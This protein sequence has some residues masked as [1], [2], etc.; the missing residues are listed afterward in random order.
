[1]GFTSFREDIVERFLGDNEIMKNELKAPKPDMIKLQKIQ[2]AIEKQIFEILDFLTDPNNSTNQ[3]LEIY[4]LKKENEKL[5][6]ECEKLNKII[7]FQ[8]RRVDRYRK[9]AKL[10]HK[11][12]KEE[13]LAI[14]DFEKFKQLCT[15][16]TKRK[17]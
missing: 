9:Y 3:T 8:N 1:M 10:L 6:S 16:L 4:A 13:K 11:R 14:A 5:K 17:R 2:D 7:E 12:I 15:P